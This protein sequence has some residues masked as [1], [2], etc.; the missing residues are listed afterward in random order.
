MKTMKWNQYTKKLQNKNRVILGNRYTGQWVKLSEE[1]YQILEKAINSDY[2]DEALLDRFLN[3]ADKDYFRKLLDSLFLAGLIVE[4][5]PTNME[6]HIDVALTHRCN[7]SCVHCCVDADSLK[8]SDPLNTEQ[9]KSVLQ[10]IV[11]CGPKTICLTGGEPLVRSDFKELLIFLGSI[12]DGDIRLM[13]NGT[14]IDQETAELIKEYISAVDISLDGV[15][16]ASCS[17]VRGNGVFDRVINSVKV[18]Q[19]RG[20]EN[21]SLSMVLTKDNYYLKDRF[22]ALNKLLGTLAAP[23]IFSPIGRGLQ[24]VSMLSPSSDMQQEKEMQNINNISE[25]N[26]HMC[27]CGAVYRNFYINYK[28]E[29]FPCALLEQKRYLL[30]NI[31]QVDSFK[32]FV[33]KRLYCTSEGY[34]NWDALQP[35]NHA[36]CNECNVNLFCWHCLHFLDLTGDNEKYFSVECKSIKKALTKVLWGEE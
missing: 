15:D 30:G 8:G 10:N 29:I 26:L 5:Q 19:E 24:N 27:S 13:T 12:Y 33:D 2:T 35:E 11:K 6:L 9:M 25:D 7:L 32:D 14:L 31:L 17:A 18:L 1:C 28:G 34:S 21:I 4:D 22:I 20:I 16:E 23:R 3:D 36:F